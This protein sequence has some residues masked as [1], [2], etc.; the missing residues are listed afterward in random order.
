M[1]RKLIIEADGGSRGNPGSAGSGSVVLD[2]DTGEVLFEVAR[3]IG[4]ATNNVAEYV[5]LISG[6]EAAFAFDSDAS[7]LVKMD[8]KLVIEQMAGRWKIKHPDMQQLAIQAQALVRGKSVLWQWIP[9][10][11]NSRADA[12]ANK[13]MD[14]EADSVVSKLAGEPSSFELHPPSAPLAAS[15]EFNAAMPSSIRAPLV[16]ATSPTSIIL[17]RH[18][19]T[20]LT[21]SKKI[22]GR[23]GQNPPL[24]PAG[25]A[26]AMAVAEEL[27]KISKTGPWAFFDEP[28]VVITSPIERANQTAR[29]IADRMNLPVFTNDNLAEISFGTWDGLT[30]EEVAERDPELWKEWR[31]SFTA[32]PPKGEALKDFDA[33]VKRGLDAV[34]SEHA[35]KVV[36]LVSHVMPIR[37]ILR[38]VLDA[39]EAAYWR[40]LISP[41]SISI[42]RCWGNQAAEV[43]AVNSTSHL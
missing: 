12:L 25:I 10:E 39:G 27:A 4:L 38:A 9:R 24:S 3:Y 31:G 22:S 33:R 5:A 14:Q 1:T 16:T 20:E 26:D 41:C 21:E 32:S 40:P 36:V 6:L 17:V 29:I 43:I 11:Q 35:G 42:I 28:Q 15:I 30:G 7:I 13:A 19:R 2:A 37:G 8:S 34:L 18:G 23:G